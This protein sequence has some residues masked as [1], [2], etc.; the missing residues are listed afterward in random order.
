MVFSPQKALPFEE[1]NPFIHFFHFVYCF[2]TQ[3]TRQWLLKRLENCFLQLFCMAE[4]WQCCLVK[5]AME[6]KLLHQH[7]ALFGLSL[8]CQFN[9][10]ISIRHQVS[11]RNAQRIGP[12]CSGIGTGIDQFKPTLYY[13][14]FL[15]ISILTITELT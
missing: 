9:V 3:T 14:R 8:I 6:A 10:I 7:V 12:S 15:S 1:R 11:I 13:L 2:L 4:K 5:V